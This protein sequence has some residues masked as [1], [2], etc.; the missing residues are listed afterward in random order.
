ME[1]RSDIPAAGSRCR[2]GSWTL[3]LLWMGLLALLVGCSEAADP[4]DA[5]ALRRHFPEQAGAILEGPFAFTLAGDAFEALGP[6]DVPAGLPGAAAP[7]PRFPRDGGALRFPLPDGSE[8][9][10][11]E[12]DALGE[13]EAEEGAVVYPRRGGASFWAALE[14]GYEEWLLLE[15]GAVRRDAPVA[16]WQVD[17]AALRQEGDAVEVADARG[18]PQVRV[19][20]PEAYG[21]DGR[22]VGVR[23]AAEGDRIA[24]WVD[25][26]GETVL[27][28]P[29]WKRTRAMNE[30]R[31]WHTAT[32]LEDGRVLVVGGR[33]VDAEL[34]S[35]EVFDPASSVWL[36]IG[37]M[38][39][40]RA[41]H[42]AT[43]LKDGRVLVTGGTHFHD[44]LDEDLASAE[45]FDP[46]SGTW[47]PV[48][49][50]LTARGRH[51]AT[52]LNDGRVLLA[53]G[54]YHHDDVDEKLASAELFDPVSGAWS[55]VRSMLAARAEH[56]AT[57]LDDGRVLVAGGYTQGGEKVA[58]A[59]L[60]D[61]AS[62]TWLAL[63]PML[64]PHAQ[65][66]ATLLKDGRVLVAGGNTRA[67][68]APESAEVFDPASQAWQ[69]AGPMITGRAGHTATLLG[70]GR[71]L[72]AGGLS[73]GSQ[74][75]SAEVFDPAVGPFDPLGSASVAFRAVEPMRGVRQSH[76]AAPLPDGRVLVA[77]G[78]TGGGGQLDT[79]EVFDPES[80]TWLPLGPMIAPRSR[81]A[82]ARL[83]DGRVL[84]AGGRRHDADVAQDGAELFDPV[85]DT[86]RSTGSM[87]T[88]RTD[89]TATLL[90]D[91]RVLVVGGLDPSGEHGDAEVFDPA[92]G[93]WSAAGPMRVA[94]TEH[95]ATRLPDGR[96]LVAGGDARSETAGLFGPVDHVE[97]FDPG[98]ST[99]EPAAP[100][101]VRR[102]RHS[103]TLLRD[104]R[105]LV[106]GG[107]GVTGD[108]DS[109][110]VFD[111]ESGQWLP[112][113]P[114]LAVRAQHVEALLPDGRVLV[115]GGYGGARYLDSAEV[116]DPALGT[117][118]PLG[119]MRTAR[120]FHSAALLPD[121]RVLVAG[122]WGYQLVA[123]EQYLDSA[124]VFDPA[125]GTWLPL[126]PMLTTRSSHTATALLDGRVLVAGGD[127]FERRPGA[128]VFRPMPDGSICTS[129][130]E[131]QSGF[132]ADS[133]CCDQPC[134]IYLCEACSDHRGA[135]ADGVCTSLHPDYAPYTCSPQTGQ[136]TSPCETVHDC[137]DGFVCEAGG[138]CIPPPNGGY[139]DK[140]GC[141]L[142]A[143]AAAPAATGQLEL[144]LLGLA[145]ASA[146][147]RRRRR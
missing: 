3:T 22:P 127:G 17:G 70:D 25:A 71:V 108:L 9:L 110:E 59:E 6:L 12:L 117:W 131:C 143:P 11:R 30:A 5:R 19:T 34:A 97:I 45:V 82:A 91:G 96:V 95:T 85:S 124:E 101:L 118:L 24:L 41:F 52:L 13:A 145:A 87:H 44:V 125:S 78:D 139:L 129:T 55:P 94:R 123:G 66:T 42:A 102:Q 86:W 58:S 21:A 114:M 53:G 4:L 92:S 72:L 65:H 128:E 39:S 80:S 104:G 116:F 57:L 18:A 107:I 144:G 50:M 15:P 36:P 69:P 23:L 105:V 113:A 115:A 88:G 79:V 122:G 63:D 1:R 133:V 98:S 10:V 77:G 51:T 43:R 67:Q 126:G 141:R 33:G 93:A 84:V 132:C 147:L 137:V 138:A 26:E 32:P 8:V 28:D 100:M 73:I 74:L 89:P 142:S 146:A 103:A 99:W 27:V 56:T 14:D 135:T 68:E 140:G 29:R 2:P 54:S 37:P 130:V 38:G 20:A 40:S 31:V 60:F 134:N 106:A 120:R 35:A 109:A 81:H 64:I 46:A 48:G 90:V 75:E 119:P 47:S 121:G 49:S 112:V 62:G 83:Q 16:T 7:R 76:A 111:P 136:P 61:P